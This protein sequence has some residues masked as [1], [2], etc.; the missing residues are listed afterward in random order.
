LGLLARYVFSVLFL[1]GWQQA[2][3]SLKRF[4]QETTHDFIVPGS[5]T[6]AI[7]LEL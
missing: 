4:P 6:F 5:P 1:S 3:R 2:N 7:N